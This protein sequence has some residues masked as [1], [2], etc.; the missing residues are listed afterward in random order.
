MSLFGND[1]TRGYDRVELN[2]PGDEPRRMSRAQFEAMPL[3]KRVRAI[4]GKQL[5]FF[6]GN[7]EVPIKEALN[8]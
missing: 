2:V 4:L 5:R 7:R 3:D 6:A 1:E 8:R